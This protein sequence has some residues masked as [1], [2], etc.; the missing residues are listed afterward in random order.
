MRRLVFL[1]HGVHHDAPQEKTRLVMR[2]TGAIILAA[3][4][5]GLFSLFIPSPWIEPFF[6]FW[7]TGYLIYGYIHCA[8]HHFKMRNP[9]ARFLKR[10]HMQHHFKKPNAHSGVSSPLWDR[11][12]RTR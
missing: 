4:F 11:V 12:F 10:Y 9:V 5:Y 1:F 7:L 6:A 3:L 8:T 2:P